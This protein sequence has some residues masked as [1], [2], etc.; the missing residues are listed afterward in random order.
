M[1]HLRKG[2]A[3]IKT[4]V[5]LPWLFSFYNKMLASFGCDTMPSLLKHLNVWGNLSLLCVCVSIYHPCVLLTRWNCLMMQGQQLGCILYLR[6][7]IIFVLLLETSTIFSRGSPSNFI[8][9]CVYLFVLN[10]KYPIAFFLLIIVDISLVT[11]LVLA[12]KQNPVKITQQKDIL[13]ISESIRVIL[14]HTTFTSKAN[15]NGDT[16]THKDCVCSVPTVIH[17][18]G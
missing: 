14:S 10:Q 1:L 13:I 3:V 6:M 12:H 8:S 16:Y 7:F 4:V 2:R 5:Y 11:V 17:N 18:K 9:Y 15:G